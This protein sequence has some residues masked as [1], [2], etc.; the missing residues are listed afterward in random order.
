[1]YQ[2][3]VFDLDG[4]LID[5]EN[6]YFNLFSDICAKFGKE[7]TVDI[8]RAQLGRP[9]IVVAA[10]IIEALCLP[11]TPEEFRAS[12]QELWQKH[13]G[14]G[15][16]AMP[17]AVECVRALR[18]QG[19]PLGLATSSSPEYREQMLTHIGIYD[20]FDVMVSGK[21]VANPKPAPDI[22]LRACQLL[23]VDPL[24]SLAVE[25]GNVGVASARAAGMPV[26]GVLDRRFNDNL[27]EATH[28]IHSLHEFTPDALVTFSTYG[29]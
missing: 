17:G 7:Y 3:I 9:N 12:E 8:H 14:V 10:Q 20:C 1:M 4:T 19:I 5:S 21:E 13:F 18:A 29:R 2:A 6:A 16:P 23:R 26:L 25:D 15:V 24:A 22:Y 11:L 27:P 28:V